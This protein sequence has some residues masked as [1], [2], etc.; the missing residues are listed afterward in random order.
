[1]GMAGYKAGKPGRV[2]GNSALDA[3]VQLQR[4]AVLGRAR[5]ARELARMAVAEDHV[6]LER[7]L[8]QLVD[9]CLV[10]ARGV[11]GVARLLGDR[12]LGGPQLRAARGRRV[13]ALVDLEVDVRPATRVGRREDAREGELA[14]LVALLNAAQVVLGRDGGVVHGVAAVPVA[15][16]QVHRGPDQRLAARGHV[17]QRDVD[18]RRHPVRLPGGAG[19]A[20]RDVAAYDTALAERVRPVRAIAREGA[21]GLV[22]DLRSVGLRRGGAAGGLAAAA[23][24]GRATGGQGGGSEAAGEQPKRAAA[25][26]E[27]RQVMAQA[28]VVLVDARSGSHVL[29]R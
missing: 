5:P 9:A 8:R 16:P 10:A 22:G 2:S 20:A 26:E 17:Q 13:E 19:E 29:Q 24:A 23:V 21:G 1:M 18:R 14:V 12:E 4:D 6:A 27:A 15:V 11:D 3:Y 7:G 28:E 25:T